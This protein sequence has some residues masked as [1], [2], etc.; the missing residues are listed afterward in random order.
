VTFAVRNG[1]TLTPISNAQNLPVGLV[2]PSDTTVGTATAVSQYNIGSQNVEQFEVA[3]IVGGNYYLNN[4]SDDAIV[5]V[6]KPGVANSI[7]GGGALLNDTN[8]PSNGYLQGAAGSDK[9]TL[10]SANVTYNKSKTNPQ[11]K[12]TVM[13]KSFNRPDGTVDS[14]LHIYLMKSTAISELT[15]PKP[16]QVSFG[17]KATIQDITNPD[18]P[19]SVDGGATLQ[20]TMT[21]DT[22]DR[23][24]IVVQKKEGGVWF[25]SGWDGQKTVEKPLDGGGN[26]SIQ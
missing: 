19:I 22:V 13:V 24:G 7:V 11:G 18:R 25:S 9:A 12:I 3:V 21:D 10:V 5:T 4:T 23:V 14:V 16:G 1:A 26:V 17:S 6:A 2:N 8:P 15:L 20:I